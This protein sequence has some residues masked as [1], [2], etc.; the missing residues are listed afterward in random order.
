MAITEAFSDAGTTIST[1]EYSLTNDSTTVA[2]QT[3][4][5]VFQAFIDFNAMAAGDAYE[6]RIL[7]KVTSGGTQRAIQTF[8]LVNV[9]LD[10]IWTHPPMV[11]LHGWDI[12]V[13]KIAGT[14][15]SIAWSIRKVA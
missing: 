12:T 3:D 5:G 14:D 11:L 1:T 15:R 4:D 13:K 6:I 7:E 9:Q 8:S 10:P 2:T